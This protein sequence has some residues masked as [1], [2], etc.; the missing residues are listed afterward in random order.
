MTK[1][2]N[3]RQLATLLLL[4]QVW[5]VGAAAACHTCLSAPH[6]RRPA[7]SADSRGSPRAPRGPAAP[8]LLH[9]CPGLHRPGARVRHAALPPP[10][11]PPPP[12][13][14]ARPPTHPPV[15][16]PLPPLPPPEPRSPRLT[17]GARL[18]PPPAA[19]P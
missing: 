16:P 14:P 12:R 3:T 4:I 2:H 8:R 9:L 18:I 10:P 13:Q 19:S 11:A 7:V 1:Q 6:R 15:P 17:P 5:M